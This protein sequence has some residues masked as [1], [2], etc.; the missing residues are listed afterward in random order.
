MIDIS[1]PYC[2]DYLGPRN[3][4]SDNSVGVAKDGAAPLTSDGTTPSVAI[5]H[6]NNSGQ[7]LTVF[8]V[9][10]QTLKRNPRCTV[11][12]LQTQQMIESKPQV[13]EIIWMK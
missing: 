10:F 13:I 11:V 12:Y 2:S 8:A 4:I 3:N 5:R 9:G 7:N 6:K 1:S